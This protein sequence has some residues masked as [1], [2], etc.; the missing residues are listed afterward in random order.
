MLGLSVDY[1]IY[2]SATLTLLLCYGD[3]LRLFLF[4]K[5]ISG[6]LLRVI[7]LSYGKL[8]TLQRIKLRTTQ[9]LKVYVSLS[10]LLFP[11]ILALILGTYTVYRIPESF[12]TYFL[13]LSFLTITYNR[14]S[15]MV[16]EKGILVSLASSIVTTVTL[17]LAVGTHYSLDSNTLFMLT[18]SASALATLIGVDLL[19]L[20]YVT[21]FKTKSV[22]MGGYGVRDAI[23][24]IPALSSITTKTIYAILTLFSYT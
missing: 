14:F 18:Y 23:F 13:L 6:D 17:M 3:R 1:V 19:N 20:R 2:V 16:F 21:F 15:V 10:G 4:S 8:R 7:D 5:T 9:K 22:I 24:L 11:V 12:T